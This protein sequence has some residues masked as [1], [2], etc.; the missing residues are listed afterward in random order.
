[1]IY[2]YWLVSGDLI[3]MQ[4]ICTNSEFTQCAKDKRLT[5]KIKKV[6]CTKFKKPHY[7]FYCLLTPA[8]DDN[9]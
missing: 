1:M 3:I 6:L 5:A 7:A 4:I 2:I 9:R 8:A